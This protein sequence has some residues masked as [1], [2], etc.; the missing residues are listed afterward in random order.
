MNAARIF[1]IGVCV[2]A[3][4]VAAAS[5]GSPDSLW[6]RAYGDTSNQQIRCITETSVNGYIFTGYTWVGDY[7]TGH[8]EVYTV[9]LTPDGDTL[10]TTNY[11]A[12]GD[13]EGY[14]VRE[15]PDGGYVTAGYTSSAVA[16]DRNVYLV[17]LNSLGGIVWEKQ[18]GGS[19][20][21]EAHDLQVLPGDSGFVIT[22]YTRSFGGYGS[23]VYLLR[24]DSA[25]D[26]LFT[27]SY[28]AT[29]NDKGYSICETTDGYV[30]C[31]HSQTA[32]EYNV[33][34]IK[35]DSQLDTVWTRTYGG[36]GLDVGLSI[37]V[38]PADF[39]FII[40]AQTDSYGA[41]SLDGWALRTDSNGDT[42]WT[43][44]VGDSL[45]NRFFSVDTTYGG[46]YVF[47]GQYGSVPFEDRK[48]YAAKLAADG[49]VE[50]EA[51]YGSP[52][53]ECV[54]LS[55]DQ[56]SD[57]RYILGGYIRPAAAGDADAFAIRLGSD[58][59]SG[60][61]PVTLPPGLGLTALPNPSGGR[62]RICFTLETKSRAQIDIYDVAGRLVRSVSG[63]TLY[64]AR[65][66]FEW[67]GKNLD[68]MKVPPGVYFCRLSSGDGRATAK[69]VLTR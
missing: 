12:F 49:A 64:P 17:K 56:T 27:R 2:F 51:T 39:G 31:G 55:V 14:A 6:M 8:S 36:P 57:G 46:G 18:Y 48:F 24:T 32:T 62:V 67:D 3:A 22:G 10:W 47:A 25:G 44:T 5:A 7:T 50:W 42:L 60:A 11:T 26:T 58:D 19:G 69:V 40:A 54:A 13:A 53:D 16:D 21:D 65:H 41:G 20:Y 23:D 4:C 59:E 9:K 35:T 29:V 43:R 28:D 30:V 63:G 34:L 1:P 66:S 38:T 68:G 15:T 52:R 33:Y 37:K 45:L 61:E